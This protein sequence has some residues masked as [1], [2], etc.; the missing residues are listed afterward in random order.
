[1]QQYV[2]YLG[3]KGNFICRKVIARLKTYSEDAAL[4]RPGSHLNCYGTGK[5]LLTF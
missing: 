5:L 4:S 3:L 1:M 2:L